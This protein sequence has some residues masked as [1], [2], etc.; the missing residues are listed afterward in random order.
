LPVGPAGPA[1]RQEELFLR[2]LVA[3]AAGF[4]GSHLVDRLLAEGNSVI[5]LDNF[6]TGRRQ[7]LTRMLDHPEALFVE[8]DVCDAF[9]VSG[10]LDW[11][12]HF[13]SPAS[14]PKYLA[15]PVETLR[16]NSEGTR[17]LL[18]L[19]RH[20][21]ARFLLAST[22]E[23]YGD[24]LVHPQPESYWGNVSCTGPRSVYDEAK[25]YAEALT[26]AYAR[27]CGVECRIIRIFNTYGPRMDAQ[28]GR[29]VTNFVVQALRGEP[30]TIYGDGS[31]TRSFQYVDD[32]V[33]GI[34]RLMAI[35]YQ[36][37][38]NL[39]NPEEYTMLQLARLVQEITETK[40]Q[41]EYRPLPQDDPKQRR[42]EISLARELLG[43]EP[44]VPVREGLGRTV[45]YFRSIL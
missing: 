31:Q 19:A 30:L 40:S 9:D 27:S 26:L 24:P 17:R 41:L 10:T 37:P 14:P 22:S 7:N 16:V 8:H 20:K 11:I 23:V 33:D 29:V 28:D 45:T 36:G 42:P 4:I 13:A 18:E 39:G 3:G 12:L 43:W 21:G 2:I 6:A 35:D 1:D 25:R 5:G 15:L 38:V 34:Q 44:K 32:L